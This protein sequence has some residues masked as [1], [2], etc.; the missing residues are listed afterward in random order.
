MR[1]LLI[2]A[3]MFC[4]SVALA[5][6]VASD[7]TTTVDTPVV[8]VL[9]QLNVNDATRSQLLTVPGLEAAQVDALLTARQEHGLL[10]TADLKLLPAEALAHLKADGES[11]YRRIR[12]LPLQAVIGGTALATSK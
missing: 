7:A 12:R 11:D 10:A 3:T 5:Q 4:T 1:K 9:G 2:A 8:R 6:P